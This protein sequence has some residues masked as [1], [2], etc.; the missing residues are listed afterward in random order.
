MNPRTLL[1]LQKRAAQL[2]QAQ[3]KPIAAGPTEVCPCG[4]VWTVAECARYDNRCPK[5]G[6]DLFV[7]GLTLNSNPV[8]LDPS[9]G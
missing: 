2:A 4:R 6:C 9:H 5:C 7:V 8:T 1:A 3:Q